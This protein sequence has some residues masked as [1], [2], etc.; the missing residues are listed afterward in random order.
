[1]SVLK[2]I[3]AGCCVLLASAAVHADVESGPK[4]GDTVS[5]LKVQT[6]NNGT[7]ADAADIVTTRD[8]HETVYVFLPKSKFDRPAGRFIKALDTA[9]QKRQV[10]HPNLQVVLVWMTD[11]VALGPDVTRLA[12]F[13][14][15]V[16]G[17]VYVVS[18]SGPV[19]RLD[20][21]P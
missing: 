3:A 1:M 11:D 10:L 21:A 7:L 17:T 5:A 16:D 4:I 12:S 2:A 6:A 20:P 14:E 19:Y 15:G 13:G 8:D 18:V 9:M